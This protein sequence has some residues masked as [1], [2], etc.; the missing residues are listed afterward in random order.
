VARGVRRPAFSSYQQAEHNTAS[1][2]LL[3][4][5]RMDHNVHS[6]P[7]PGL[8]TGLPAGGSGPDAIVLIDAH[9]HIHDT[10]DVGAFLDCAAKQ[11]DAAALQL[12]LS[13]AVPGT[14][15]LTESDGVA[16]FARLASQAGRRVGR[17][18]VERTG[19]AE[20][21]RLETESAGPLVV[22]AGRQVVTA[23]R[24]EVLALGTLATFADGQP[25]LSVIEQ[26]QAA[27]AL[28]VVPWGFGKWTGRRGRVVESLLGLPGASRLFV[29][30]SGG[31]LNI[32]P[33]PA[34]FCVA[35]K[36]G[37][38]ILPGS[39][40]L[41]FA[42]QVGRVLGYGFVLD[43]D[44]TGD[45]PATAIKRRLQASRK[46]PPMFG[47][48]TAFADFVRCQLAMQWHKRRPAWS[49]TAT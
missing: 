27:S 8:T 19:D 39:D 10:F 12:G 46:Q 23:E 47:R 33:E 16:A 35:R 2:P 34:L 25:I 22:V 38:P 5:F 7:N 26:M 17:W 20:A 40:P 28:A 1:A 9:V 21:L 45:R 18:H 13:A 37:I 42:D 36:Q 41:P 14:L 48:R 32:G 6:E 49:A 11:R 43:A 3:D 29:G 4:F 24:L 30:D 44:V 15:M 31:R